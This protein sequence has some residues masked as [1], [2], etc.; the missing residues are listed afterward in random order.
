MKKMTKSRQGFNMGNEY[1]GVHCTTS[2]HLYMFEFFKC[3]ITV[4]KFF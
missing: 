3:Y 1:T 2:L 4:K